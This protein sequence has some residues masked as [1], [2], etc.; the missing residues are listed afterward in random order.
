M[1]KGKPPM[2]KSNFSFA[3]V[4]RMA[5]DSMRS[6]PVGSSRDRVGMVVAG[7]ENVLAAAV[8]KERGPKLKSGAGWTESL[9]HCTPVQHRPG[10]NDLGQLNRGKPI[11]Y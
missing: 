2:P 9:R 4:R 1:L 10:K 8:G 7:N 5:N 6:V 3:D 11:T